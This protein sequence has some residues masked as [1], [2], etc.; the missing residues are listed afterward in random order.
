MNWEP[1]WT[2]FYSRR[3]HPS[4]DCK[5]RK[6]SDSNLFPGADV[7]TIF[8]CVAIQNRRITGLMNLDRLAP[9]SWLV[10]YHWLETFF[11]IFSYL[12]GFLLKLQKV[13]RKNVKDFVSRGN[14]HGFRVNCLCS[15]WAKSVRFP[16]ANPEPISL[17]VHILGVTRAKTSRFLPRLLLLIVVHPRQPEANP[18]PR[19]AV[20]LWKICLHFGMDKNR[21]RKRDWRRPPNVGLAR[22]DKRS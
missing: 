4:I 2:N 14:F 16:D 22:S 9:D 18:A 15:D 20:I 19:R 21:R 11:F 8:P 1:K 10:Y 5:G 6:N 7:C 17:F 13:V 12:H 3:I